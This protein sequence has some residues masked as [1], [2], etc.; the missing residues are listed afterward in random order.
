M[1][2]KNEWGHLPP[3]LRTQLENVSREEA[4]P[5]REEL[6]KRYYMS[7]NKKNRGREE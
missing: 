3:E 6:I 2:D 5:A 4:L 7:L 1:G